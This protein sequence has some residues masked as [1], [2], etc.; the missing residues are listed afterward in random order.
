[1]GSQAPDWFDRREPFLEAL[2]TRLAPLEDRAHRLADELTV[3][4]N[5]LRSF[6]EDTHRGLADLVKA[7]SELQDRAD[8]H[9]SVLWERVAEGLGEVGETV[10][11]EGSSR[12]EEV[13]TATT[14]AVSRAEESLRARVD[15]AEK[16]ASERIE[17]TRR[18]MEAGFEHALH[19]TEAGFVQTRRAAEESIKQLRGAALGRLEEMEKATQARIG[20]LETA[21]G[22]AR[23]ALET[24]VASVAD[25]LRAEQARTADR[26]RA[27]Q[28]KAN[29]RLSER[30]T[31]SIGELEAGFARISRLADSMETLGKKRAF[32]E[33]VRSEEALREEQ[34]EF[35][36]R[37]RETGS[38]V[39]EEAGSLS[40]RIAQLEERL[41]ASAEELEALE[42]LPAEASGRVTEAV[43]RMRG[44]LEALGRRFAGE[45]GGSIE[46]IRTELEAG[47]P[48]K[49]LLG[50]LAELAR[51]QGDVS[52]AQRELEKL[53][54]SVGSEVKHLRRAIEG[55]GKPRTAPQLAEELQAL[56]GRV[57]VIEGEVAGLVEAVSARVT[58]RVLE[59]LQTRKRRG[60][61]R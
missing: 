45:L 12:A 47:V 15:E 53:S 55:W 14:D 23:Q 10:R 5:E 52:R 33:L 22:E 51:S 11:R 42:R 61:R 44:D 25:G 3:V 1:V 18:S 27:D 40:R 46:R 4:R 50:R 58:E 41:R 54:A 29:Q 30:M 26:M 8:E 28:A 49:E 36:G 19:T 24:A 37:L 13:T 38:A 39:A 32:Q 9:A 56:E 43:E 20:E 31:K 60:L 16:A 7:L 21:V 57:S 17:G 6:A 35:V 59:A 48:V 34:A 2:G